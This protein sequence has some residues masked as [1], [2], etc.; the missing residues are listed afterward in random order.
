[1]AGNIVMGY[2]LLLDA[3]RNEAFARSAEVYNNMAQAEIARHSEF[4][5]KFNPESI[6]LYKA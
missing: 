4:I 5:S 3:A 2:L 6:E 1:M